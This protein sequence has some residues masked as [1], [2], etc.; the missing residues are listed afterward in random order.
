M[1]KIKAEKNPLSEKENK[2]L[3]D[4]KNDC[5]ELKLKKNRLE[6]LLLEQGINPAE[7]YPNNTSSDESSSEGGSN[8]SSSSNESSNSRANKRVKYSDS[9]NNVDFSL[10]LI[11]FNIVP[12]LRMLLTLF[13]VIFLLVLD[14]N[15]L[16]KIDLVF[17]NIELLQVL[18]LL[19]IVNITKLIYR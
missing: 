1:L 3:S 4:I 11:V 15:L 9:G 14:F 6:E 16:P 13:S 2:L 17:I 10:G 8:Y 12:V 7:Q 5:N 18:F 19:L